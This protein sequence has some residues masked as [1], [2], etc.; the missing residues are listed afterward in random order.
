MSALLGTESLADGK[1]VIVVHADDFAIAKKQFGT[2]L[3]VVG[4]NGEDTDITPLFGRRV[5]LIGEAAARHAAMLYA[6]RGDADVKIVPQEIEPYLERDV[7][8]KDDPKKVLIEGPFE[9]AKKNAFIYAPSTE[10]ARDSSPSPVTPFSGGEDTDADSTLPEVP[11]YLLESLPD[12]ALGYPDSSAFIG[13]SEPSSPAIS[14]QDEWPE[15]SNIFSEVLPSE[16]AHGMLPSFAEDMI[17]DVSTRQGTDP[18]MGANS[19]LTVVSACC[20]DNFKLQMGIQDDSWRVSPRLWAANVADSARGKSPAMSAYTGELSASDME[21]KLDVIRNKKQHEQAMKVYAAQEKQWIEKAK[22]DS[23]LVFDVAEPEL[24]QDRCVVVNNFTLAYMWEFLRSHR[25]AFVVGDELGSVIGGFD[26]FQ[27]GSSERMEFLQL[28]EGGSYVTGRIGRGEFAVKN[29]SICLLGNITP[30]VIRE[31]SRGGLQADGL[32]QRMMLVCAREKRDRIDQKPNKQ[33]AAAF[34]KIVHKLIETDAPSDAPFSMSTGAFECLQ[35]FVKDVQK[36]QD[37][38]GYSEPHKSHLGK[39]EGMSGRI[40]VTLHLAQAIERGQYPDPVIPTSL[41]ENVCKLM[42]EWLIPNIDHFWLSVLGQGK[43]GMPT[44]KIA[45]WIIGK[46]GET[47]R[48]ADI[49]NVLGKE[50]DEMEIAGRNK[51]ITALNEHGFI[52]SLHEGRRTAGV[53]PT[54][55]QINPRVYEKFAH[56]IEP[57]RNR[58]AAIKSF[59]NEKKQ[60][61]AARR[62]D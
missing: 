46:G 41:A 16:F 19:W 30:S 62:G 22:N 21:R 18:G 45:L 14:V 7:Y 34:S 4:C 27:N 23:A 36:M 43:V 26:R 53:L 8:D 39:L 9:W 47:M 13:H 44:Q 5:I 31:Q 49:Q 33:A 57:E 50:W 6:V 17:F 58:R 35:E 24:A 40:M 60:A 12:D 54:R 20:D 11:A 56:M 61:A 52:S 28:Y 1:Q 15:P 10:S 29:A 38:G 37:F 59:L 51:I 32:L 55:H 42:R 48:N 3:P 2:V 25:K